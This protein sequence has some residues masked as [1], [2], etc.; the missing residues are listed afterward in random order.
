MTMDSLPVLRPNVAFWSALRSRSNRPESTAGFHPNDRASPRKSMTVNFTDHRMTAIPVPMW[1]VG[2]ALVG[3]VDEDGIVHLTEQDPLVIV[4]VRKTPE[5]HNPAS[6][7]N[8]AREE[9]PS[10]RW[11]ERSSIYNG[12]GMRGEAPPY[13]CMLMTRKADGSVETPLCQRE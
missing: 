12:T 6:A 1:A 13:W 11:R 2:T 7:F 10:L 8:R 5:D 4:V 9:Y 3:K